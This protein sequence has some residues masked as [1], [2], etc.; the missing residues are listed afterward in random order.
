MTLRDD[1]PTDGEWLAIANNDMDQDGRFYYAVTTT[2]I[3]CR[4]SCKSKTPRRDRVRVFKQAGQAA[5]AGFRPC[6]RCKPT[7]EK[8]PDEEWLAVVADYIDAHYAERLTLETL[9][10][11]CHGS[12]YHLHR[13]FKRIRGQTPAEYVQEVRIGR[14]K[15]LLASSDE[16]VSE[17]GR[18]VGLPNLPYFTTLF[19]KTTGVTPARYRLSMV[20]NDKGETKR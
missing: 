4:P 17:I 18:R 12:P 11:V 16:S 2:G 14:A 3:F 1:S 15:R 8:P 13:T 7:G 19:K 6:K 5:S 20:Q 10:D 9:A